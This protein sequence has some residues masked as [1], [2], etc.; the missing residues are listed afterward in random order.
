MLIL[1]ILPLYHNPGAENTFTIM[2][3]LVYKQAPCELKCKV[4]LE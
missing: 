2:F 1:W 4:T 3:L